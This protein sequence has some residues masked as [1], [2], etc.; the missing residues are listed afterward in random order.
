MDISNGLDI[1]VTTNEPG[2]ELDKKTSPEIF[3]DIIDL[4]I[5]EI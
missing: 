5:I 2:G 1:I 3:A 4:P